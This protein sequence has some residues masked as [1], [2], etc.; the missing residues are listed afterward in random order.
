[1]LKISILQKENLLA[2]TQEK[3]HSSA[4]RQTN[5]DLQSEFFVQLFLQRL[6]TAAAA[7]LS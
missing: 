3:P 4:Q 6:P 5:P 2:L 7:S 1:M